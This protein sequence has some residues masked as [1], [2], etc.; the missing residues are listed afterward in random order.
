MDFWG[1]V[2]QNLSTPVPGSNNTAE[3]QALLEAL[4]YV[5]RHKTHH[6]IR[7]INLF[8]DSQL[9]YDFLHGLSIPKHHQYLLTQIRILIDHLLPHTQIALIKV[10]GH[11]GHEG[12]E[13]ADR[14]AKAGVTSSSNLGRHSHPVRA[15]LGE[16][17]RMNAPTN[18][19]TLSLEEQAS[20]LQQAAAR[21]APRT[22][23]TTLYKKEYLSEPTKRIID[24][25]AQT[26][27]DDQDLLKKLRKAVKRR[28]RKD[29]KQH[30]CNNLLQDSKGPPSQQW[31]TLKHLRKDY[32]PRTQGIRKPNGHMSTKANK[33]EV[34]A[35]HLAQNVWNLRDLPPISN[36]PLYDTAPIDTSPFT[37][38]EL[39]TALARLKNR[40]APGPDQLP[41]EIWKY[42]PREVHKA[43]LAHFTKAFRNAESPRSWKVADIVMIFKGK[44]K[45]PTLP[46]SYRPISLI[47]TVY[48]IYACLLH[49]RLKA[50]IDD[51]ISPVQFGFRAGKSTSTPLFVLRRLLELHE[52]H[53]ESFYALFLDWSQA[54]DSVSH[55]ALANALGRLGVPPQFA[56]P[57]LSIYRDC[58]FTVKDSGYNSQ[59][60]TF[61]QGIRQGCP[62][63][64]YLFIVTLSVLFHDTYEAYQHTFGPRPSVLTSDFQ[65]DRPR[66]RG[67]HGV[68]VPNTPIYA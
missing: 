15:P 23:Q 48:K 38:Q 28:A 37:E 31:S 43:L 47:N 20:I 22:K 49:Q 59:P 63:S 64:P 16:T 61:A 54:F 33:P 12:N 44:K 9:A 58:Q 1:P 3:L 4:D 57:V 45:D 10:K 17:I 51:R 50:S 68:V 7:K 46:T 62:L 27:P 2:G 67:R 26:P 25:I 52:R 42:A 29:K 6:H 39:M 11:A 36:T 55:V 40:K 66:I 5:A 32:V 30:P 60:K 8:T 24:R 35:E 65:I 34:L 14:L 53:Q 13:R 41:S 18:F 19:E 56:N 21:A